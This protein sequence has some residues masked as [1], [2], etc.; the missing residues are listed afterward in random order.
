M[1]GDHKGCQLA[2]KELTYFHGLPE[3]LG[4]FAISSDRMLVAVSSLACSK[5]RFEYGV[6]RCWSGFS[7]ELAEDLDF[8]SSLWREIEALVI[9][10]CGLVL[11]ISALPLAN[12]A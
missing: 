8:S 3:E 9:H 11:L 1:E 4:A 7:N 6:M 10:Y 5:K 12:L 2:G